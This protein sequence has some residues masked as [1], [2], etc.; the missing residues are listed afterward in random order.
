MK[1]VLDSLFRFFKFLLFWT[2]VFLFL[3]SQ[4]WIRCDV[5]VDGKKI[6]QDVHTIIKS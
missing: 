3:L 1:E 5:V 4:G 6:E 2:I